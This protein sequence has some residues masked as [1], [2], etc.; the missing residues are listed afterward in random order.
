MKSSLKITV[1]GGGT[2]SFTVLSGLK[3]Y[4][5]YV[6]ALVN[7]ADDGGSTGRLRSDLGVLPP[8]DVRQCLVALSNSPELC[9]LFN[10][11]FE[12]G[13]LRGHAFGNLFLSA[14]EKTTGS[15][16]EAVKTTAE[17]LNVKGQV[18]PITLSDITLCLKDGGRV[19]KSEH[20]IGHCTLDMARPSLWLEPEAVLNPRA[21]DAIRDADVVVIAPGNLYGSLAPALIVNGVGEALQSTEAEV[22]Y[23]CNLMTKAG[24]TDEFYVHDFANEIERLAGGNILDYVLYNTDDPTAEMANAYAKNGELSVKADKII[25]E[26]ANYRAIGLPLVAQAVHQRP[27]ASDS[28]AAQRTLIRH[29]SDRVAREIVKIAR[30]NKYKEKIQDR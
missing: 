14:L 28:L 3:Q 27:S 16:A 26:K 23:V 5:H 22:I 8:G 18:E 24:Q 2:G 11:R 13:E 25:M 7:M 17:V 4:E 20:M 19:I 30:S 10:Y 6:T 29:D 21:C 9:K 1:I 12:E 15:F